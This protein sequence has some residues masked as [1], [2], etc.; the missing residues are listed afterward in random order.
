MPVEYLILPEFDVTYVKY[1][2][3]V[4]VSQIALA[5]DV[6]QSDKDFKPGRGEFADLSNVV[7][8]DMKFAN[9]ASHFDRMIKSY[10]ANGAKT[11]T[12]IF[13]PQPD[14]AALAYAYAKM[15]QTSDILEARVYEDADKAIRDLGLT[16]P[17]QEFF[18]EVKACGTETPR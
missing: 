13:A 5:F 9:V 16:I 10:S 12:A 18:D 8:F 17:A 15:T 6:H 3:R 7:K 1:Y 11:L 2:G 4:T 14:Q